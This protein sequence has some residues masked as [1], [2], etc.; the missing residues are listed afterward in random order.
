MSTNWRSV[1]VALLLAPATTWAQGRVVI[2]GTPHR[3][4]RG[5]SAENRR[6]GSVFSAAWE[7]CHGHGRVVMPVGA[8]YGGSSTST[9]TSGSVA[10]DRRN[11]HVADGR[12][13][14]GT[15]VTDVVG[16]EG[17]AAAGSESR[18]GTLIGAIAGAPVAGAAIGAGVAG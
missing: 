4:Q 10:P 1:L 7:A 13:A 15:V 8:P 2:R 5:L 9:A 3:A 6:N 11:A 16:A 12:R 17:G 14:R 18:S